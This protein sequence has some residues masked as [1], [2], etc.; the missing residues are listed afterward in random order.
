MSAGDLFR[1]AISFA[2]FCALIKPK[3]LEL[4]P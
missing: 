4:A 2:A 3:T 1:P